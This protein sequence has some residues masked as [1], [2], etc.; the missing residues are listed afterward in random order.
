MDWMHQSDMDYPKTLL[1]V[2]Q[3]FSPSVFI[4]DLVRVTQNC[5]EHARL[6]ACVGKLRTAVR[7]HDT[8]SIARN[9]ISFGRPQIPGSSDLRKAYGY[10]TC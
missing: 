9:V 1:W 2:V 6:Q 4:E 10:V 8:W 5:V 7:T 3:T